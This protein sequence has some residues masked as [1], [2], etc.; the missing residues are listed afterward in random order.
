M[1][2]ERRGRRWAGEPITPVQDYFD[3]LMT[4]LEAEAPLDTA[5]ASVRRDELACMR[6]VWRE[7]ARTY[8]VMPCI[9]A[10]Q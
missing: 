4:Q 8:S 5:A 9:A 10:C 1:S 7:G 2:H 6:R 3:R